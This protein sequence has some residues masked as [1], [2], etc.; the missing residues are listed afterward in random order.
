M[1]EGGI[2]ASYDFIATIPAVD[3]PAYFFSGAN[4]YNTPLALVREYYDALEAPEK[5]LVVFEESAHLPFLAETEKFTAEVI[6]VA[7]R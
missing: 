5:E 6:R 4:D 1:H 7:T 3:V 2:M